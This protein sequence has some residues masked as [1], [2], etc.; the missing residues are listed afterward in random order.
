[1]IIRTSLLSA[2]TLALVGL[3][4]YVAVADIKRLSAIPDALLG[5][6]ATSADDC[7]SAKESY[8][9]LSATTYVNS[10]VNCTVDW[11]SETAGTRGSIYSAHLRCAKPGGKPTSSNVV[12]RQRDA[13][14]ILAGPTFNGLRTYGRCGTTEPAAAK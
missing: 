9:V 12:I 7:K 6:W 13:N 3:A 8:M 11:V 10:D 5:S 14:H 4:S 2:L 1:M